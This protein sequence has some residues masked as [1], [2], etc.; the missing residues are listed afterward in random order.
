M[1]AIY[2]TFELQYAC[3]N[4]ATVKWVKGEQIYARHT[5]VCLK[6]RL[7]KGVTFWCKPPRRNANHAQNKV[8]HRSCKGNFDAVKGG[9]AIKLAIQNCA[10]YANL[11]FD[12]AVKQLA[13]YKIVSKLVQNHCQRVGQRK[14][15]L[16]EKQRQRQKQPK[17]GVDAKFY[18]CH[19][20]CVSLAIT[21]LTTAPSS[22]ITVENVP[23]YLPISVFCSTVSPTATNTAVRFV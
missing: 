3:Y 19:E 7:C 21:C 6:K 11:N 18:A 14:V 20:S 23:W 17:A 5:D 16:L 15:A 13:R 12:T 4:S 8:D 9:Y 22:A 2:A 1:G 10:K